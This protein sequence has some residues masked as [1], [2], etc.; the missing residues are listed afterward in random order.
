MFYH[1][2]MVTIPSQSKPVQSQKNTDQFLKEMFHPNVILLI[3]T[4]FE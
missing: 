4:G 3:R 1:V 2:S